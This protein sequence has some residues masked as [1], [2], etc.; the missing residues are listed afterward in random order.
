MARE[1]GIYRAGS[2]L[3]PWHEKLTGRAA[4][5]RENTSHQGRPQDTGTTTVVLDTRTGTRTGSRKSRVRILNS[6]RTSSRVN[7]GPSLFKSVTV[8]VIIDDL[9]DTLRLRLGW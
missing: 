3:R 1:I 9:M 6:Q 4:P 2:G 7:G 5:P 8:T